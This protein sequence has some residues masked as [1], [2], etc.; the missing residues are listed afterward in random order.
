MTVKIGLVHIPKTGGNTLRALFEQFIDRSH[1]HPLIP[2][3]NPEVPADAQLLYGHAPFDVY[4]T[5]YDLYTALRHPV[6]RIISYYEMAK[7]S[8]PQGWTHYEVFN[9][10]GK[11]MTLADFAAN[12]IKMPHHIDNGMTRQLAGKSAYLNG[13]PIT[14]ADLEKAKA[15]LLRT[16]FGLTERLDELIRMI[17]G[18]YGWQVTC[19]ENAN[20][21]PSYQQQYT[22]A[23]RQAVMERQPYDMALYAWAVEE[24]ERRQ[25]A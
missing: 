15:N 13:N 16:T 6:D 22:A 17:A 4:P 10:G 18:R 8:T 5:G 1:S 20:V 12:R 25:A 2:Y 24:Y 9:E 19:Y 14:K 11:I 21:A 7:R 23:D 3:W